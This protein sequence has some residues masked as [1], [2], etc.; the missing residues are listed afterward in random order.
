MKKS[1]KRI[2][3]VAA[4]LALALCVLSGCSD[5]TQTK[6]DEA[7][8][9]AKEA[10][11]KEKDE[12]L[13]AAQTAADEA[14]K[15]AQD[16]ADAA[17]AE[18]EGQVAD[19]TGKL[20]AAEEA[21]K[22]AAETA[23]KEKDEALAAAQTAADEALASAQSAADEALK[24]AQEAADAAK[25]ELEG[26]V[27][28]LTDKLAASEEAAKTAAE[29]A[30]KEKDE[31]LAAAQTA[32]DEA[33][34]SAQEAADAAKAELEG[35]VA[36]LT[37]QVEDVTSAAAKS[38]D[39]ALKTAQEAAEAAKTELEGKVA[40]LTKQLEDAEA[41]AK[42]AAEAAAKEKDEAV[43]AAVKAGEEAVEAAKAELQGQVD[44]LTKQLEEAKAA[45]TEKAE[46]AVEEKKE[47]EPAAEA[48]AAMSH[49]DYIAAE[50]DSEVC[51]ETYVQGTQSWWDNKIT[52]YAQSEDGAYFIYNMACSE[53]D[54]AKLVPG[55][56][57]RVKG[58]KSEWAGEVEITDAAFEILEG[59]PFIAE[60]EDITAL[61]GKDE[62]KDH[63]NE[64]VLFKGLTVAAQDD[65]EAINYKNATEKTDDIYVRFT[66]A[67]GE[68]FNFCVEFYLTGKDTD[69]Y[70]AVEGLQVGDV[71]DVEGF[72]YWYEGPN[73]HITGV[74]KA[75]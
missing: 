33:L 61:L 65:G 2:L 4:I 74:T 49:A 71:V 64:K 63:Q 15:S 70:K 25:A 54:S 5:N 20:T 52:V 56:K 43:A 23:A 26:Q 3:A 59:D 29:A 46:E 42:A 32:A 72:L 8:N 68:V 44:E 57:I 7:V 62:L 37:K 22:T 47:E 38:A 19:L 40:D 36:D 11:I 14:L 34:K 1:W 16:A 30:A 66:N 27:K 60:P 50:L 6:I 17:K 51:V 12:A 75:E 55:T 67:D 24:S 31:A 39:E 10:L 58:F 28:D 41:N 13:A 18:L 9:S 73:T 21:A 48:P 69:A 35:K 45:V 53:E